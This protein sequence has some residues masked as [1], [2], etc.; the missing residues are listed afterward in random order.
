MSLQV[1][2]LGRTIDQTALLRDVDFEAHAGETICVVGPSGA[3]KTTLLRLLAGL[4]AP[5]AGRIICDERDL[6]NVPAELRPMA[7]VFQHDT[8]F[9]ELTV[10][11]NV[12]LG[13]RA[14]RASAAERD[15]ATQIALLRLGL[16]GLDQR[17]PAELSGG[18]QRRVS[19]ARALAL[20]PRVLLLDEPMSGLDDVLRSQLTGQLRQLQHRAHSIVIQATHDVDDALATADRLLVLD[21]G[22]AVQIGTPIEVFTRPTS[23][24]VAALMGRATF[25]QADVEACAT[26]PDGARARIRVL[27]ATLDVAAHP[28]LARTRPASAPLVVRPHAITLAAVEPG[29]AVRDVFGSTG[30]VQQRRYRGD[31]VDLVV[32]TE[33]GTIIVAAGLDD[34]RRAGDPVR[35]QLDPLHLWLLP[36]SEAR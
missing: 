15:E 9:P 36:A 28:D 1:S 25:L 13:L 34:P 2:G 5:S 31:H 17:Y 22:R 20:R 10:A 30:L 23:A 35:V 8:L 26:T 6:T 4:D 21:R 33:G 11:E 32:E 27:G 3:G 18:Q 7:M 29:P 19:V 16:G 24:R 14:R 12:A